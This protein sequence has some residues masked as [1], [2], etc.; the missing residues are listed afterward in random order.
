MKNRFDSQV[1]WR[2]LLLIGLAIVVNIAVGRL[3]R[4]VL[5]W[6]LWLDSIGTVLVGALRGPLAGAATGAATN[7]LVTIFADN[8][9]A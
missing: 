5:H 8:R 7:L 9:A 1:L 4:E 2:A 6:P 3:V